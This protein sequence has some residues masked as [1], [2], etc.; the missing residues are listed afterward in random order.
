MQIK[1]MDNERNTNVYFL[2]KS[3]VNSSFLTD[4][5]LCARSQFSQIVSLYCCQFIYQ[6]WRTRD[7]ISESMS[8]RKSTST[9]YAPSPVFLQMSSS[10]I[11][12]HLDHSPLTSWQTV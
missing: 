9:W 5:P 11:H 10:K 12:H 3:L 2:F 6:E 4:I 1:T 7:I 8:P